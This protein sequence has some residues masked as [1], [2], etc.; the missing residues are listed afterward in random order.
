MSLKKIQGRWNKDKVF[1]SQKEI[2]ELQDFVKDVLNESEIFGLK[3][4]LG[5]TA[6]KKR[7]YEFTIETSRGGRHAD[8]V[9]FIN[10]EGVVIPV[11]VERHNNIKKGIEQIFQYQKDWDKKY[12]I[13]TDGNEWRFYRSNKFK[14]FYIDYI[15]NNTKDFLIY[16]HEYIKPENYYIDLFSQDSQEVTERLDLNQQENRI[17][18]FDD[19]TRVMSNFKVKMRAIGAFGNLFDQRIHEK[20]AVETSYAYLIQFILY[21][22]LVDNGYKK[23]NDEYSSTL[24]KIQKAL[25]D[26]DFYSIIINEIKNISEYISH[27]I[28][29]PFAEE[30]KSINTKLID[31]LKGDLTID[32]IAP[33]LDIILFIN[34]YNF[35][36]L[37]NEIFGYIY[38]NYLKDLYDEKNKG[39]YFTDAAVVNFMLKEIGYTENKIKKDVKN[40]RI[41]IIDPSCGAGTFLYSAADKIIS[42]FD[43]GT[44]KQSK[45]IEELV[46]KNI[47][48][49]DIEEF[50]LYLAEMNILMRLLPLIVNDIYEN[51]IDNKLKIFKT[52][53][54]ISE[55][56]DTGINSKVE[57]GINLF[58]HLDKTALDYPSFMRDEKDLEDMLKTLQENGG[59]RE[60]FDFVIGNPPYVSYNVCSRQKIEFI[61]RMQDK[62]D[63]T[64][65]M[66]N[67]YGMNLNTAEGR[68]KT[69]SPK[70]NLYTFFIALGLALLK[71][72][73]YI[74]YI[75]P[76]TVLVNADLDV[77]RYHLSEFTTIEKIITFDGKMF[78]GRGLK[79]NKP[80]ATS[81]LIFVA[82][83]REPKNDHKI[84]IINYSNY[85]DESGI[86]FDKYI[87]SRNKIQKEVSQ[88][89]L[90]SNVFNWAF[91]KY[92]EMYH[93]CLSDYNKHL[94]I[95]D[96]RY[97]L[98]HYDEL[99]LDG[100]VNLLKKDIITDGGVKEISNLY[101][102]PNLDKTKQKAGIL[103]YFKKDKNIKKAQ[104]SRDFS[105]LTE[106]KFKILWKYINFDG[107]YFMSG[108]DVLPMYQQYCIASNNENEI[109]FLYGLLNS[110]LNLYLLEKTFKVGN[111]DKLTYI[112]G[113]TFIKEFIHI[114][115][116]SNEN[117][118]VKNE[119]IKQVMKLLSFE[120]FQ[121][122]DFINFETSKQKFDSVTVDG[123][124][125]V[126]NDNE[127]VIKFKIKSNAEIIKTKID[128]KFNSKNAFEI[129]LHNLKFLEIIDKEQQS[130]YQDYIDD[131]VFS[132]YFNIPLNNLGIKNAENIKQ[133]CKNNKYYNYLFLE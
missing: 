17:L 39:Q 7:K 103:G 107:F 27:H 126:L 68:I 61:K 59:I 124:Y 12:A 2:G 54:S 20:I 37:K 33:W 77:I 48:G 120:D 91:I 79:Q 44:E 29:I 22:V 90:K 4:G 99:I 30:Q 85:T 36:G 75:I 83:K 67:V 89:E 72:D 87:K 115:K 116:I 66:G 14:S 86:D 52:K 73:G 1:F 121:L 92:D 101:K 132:L 118:N 100:S 5:S 105:I 114:P 23:F 51:P 112:L 35:S 26:K 109:Y 60:R 98:K 64:T 104:G 16:W 42:A 49:F 11:E 28:Y 15:F 78:I 32:D 127:D 69:Y 71:N 50:P 96:Y 43:D 24:T 113:L 25:K 110:K 56:L 131:L 63:S 9:I 80:V 13:L 111:E 70:P 130:L 88:S 62:N 74:C 108:E 41:S 122:K 34:R 102:I 125:L 45:Y 6:N 65:N 123:Q 38:E 47:F 94:T 57:E 129:T 119:I 55:F 18:F 117:I 133:L 21:K 76:Q 40:N 93:N 128:N 46:D 31:N 8:F 82:K 84:K 81:S 19:V 106:R 53:D 97:S 58:N 10:G 95:D 3:K